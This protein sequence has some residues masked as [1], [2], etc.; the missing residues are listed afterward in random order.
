MV[1]QSSVGGAPTSLLQFTPSHME[2][3]RMSDMVQHTK[4]YVT[5]LWSSTPAHKV[6][7]MPSQS[8]LPLAKRIFNAE[9]LSRATMQAAQPKAK[10]AAPIARQAHLAAQHEVKQAHKAGKV[11]YVYLPDKVNSNNAYSTRAQS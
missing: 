3:H 6:P 5:G 1:R 4:S 11:A 2:L 10:P 9:S 7:R 8:T